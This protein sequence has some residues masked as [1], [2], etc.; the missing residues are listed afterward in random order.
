MLRIIMLSISSNVNVA[1]IIKL[2]DDLGNCQHFPVLQ[3]SLLVFYGNL[4]DFLSKNNFRN[5]V[6]QLERL[7]CSDFNSFQMVCPSG[8]SERSSQCIRTDTLERV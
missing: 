3:R 6:H 8:Q 4:L 5:Q 1:T 7:R 2:S